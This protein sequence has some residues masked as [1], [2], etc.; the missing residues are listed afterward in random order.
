V[1]SV[2]AWC[3]GNDLVSP[4]GLFSKYMKTAADAASE[5]CLA[6]DAGGKDNS[7]ALSHAS[8]TNATLPFI[9][10]PTCKHPQCPTS[11]AKNVQKIAN[12]IFAFYFYNIYRVPCSPQM[13]LSQ[14][15][16]E[17]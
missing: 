8:C 13:K 3:A 11:C 17:V 2:Y 16:Y 5:R 12:K 15:G 6:F 10:E 9:C 7:S 4:A 1:Q 14:V